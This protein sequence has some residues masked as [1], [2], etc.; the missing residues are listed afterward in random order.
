M[1]DLIERM[2]L[3]TSDAFRQSDFSQLAEVAPLEK[4]VDSLQQEVKV[5][6]S[7]LGRVGLDE[8]NSRRSIHIIDYAI[9]LEHIGDIIEKGLFRR[10]ARRSPSD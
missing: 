1:G 6:L 5:Y 3:K 7:K 4:R 10:S 8:E 9:N 2:L